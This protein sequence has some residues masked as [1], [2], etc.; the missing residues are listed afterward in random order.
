MRE[1]AYREHF[2]VEDRH[3]WFRGRWA[4]IEALLS[5]TPLPQSPKILDAGCG[6]GGNLQ[7]YDQLGEAEGVD[8]APEAV[9]FCRERGFDSVQQAGLEDLPFE[10]GRF[11]LIAATDVLEHIEAEE[12]ALRELWRVAAPNGALLLTVPAYMWLWSAEDENLHHQRRYTRARLRQ[13]VQRTGWEPQIATYFN[14]LLLPPIALARRLPRRS[15]AG[16]EVDRT[17]PS[18]DGVLSLPM[19]F[20]ARLIR[21]GV[22]LPAGVSVG[23]VC[24]KVG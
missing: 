5:R 12:A 11:D 16:A 10:D 4:V 1:A 2:E 17:P 14:T 18:L 21:A 24:R 9:E 7:R 6:T 20:E 15:S 23:I 3:W 19:R 8:P 22:R 13:A